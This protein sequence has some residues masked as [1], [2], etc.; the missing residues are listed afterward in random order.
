MS[1]DGACRNLARGR[2][3][4]EPCP[5]AEHARGWNPVTRLGGQAHHTNGTAKTSMPTH[6]Q[7]TGPEHER[8]KQARAV[9]DKEGYLGAVWRG[10][11]RLS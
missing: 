11:K 8:K 5:G 7:K 4:P 6:E 3:V 9:A 10:E 1:V 2:S